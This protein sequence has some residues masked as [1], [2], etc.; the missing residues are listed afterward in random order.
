V[1][2]IS[3]RTRIRRGTGESAGA[4]ELAV[5]QLVSV[6]TEPTFPITLACRPG[7]VAAVVVIES[8]GDGPGG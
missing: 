7:A 2:T 5:G 1:F 6:W 3:D 4:A 8:A